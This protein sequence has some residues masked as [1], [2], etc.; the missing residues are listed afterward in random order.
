VTALRAVL[1]DPA[2]ARRRAA[3]LR[4]RMLRERTEASYE[5]QVTSVLL[6]LDD[7]VDQPAKT[8]AVS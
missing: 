8:E 1:A 2:D 6:G 5:R 3:G 4:E 7:T